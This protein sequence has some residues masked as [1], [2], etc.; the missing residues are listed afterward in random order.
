MKQLL[1]LFATLIL[2]YSCSKSKPE[3]KS[4]T[5][6]VTLQYKVNGVETLYSGD[7]GAPNNEGIIAWKHLT[8]IGSFDT[9]YFIQALKGSNNLIGIGITTDSLHAGRSYIG[10]S[11]F[12]FIVFN[13][14]KYAISDNSGLFNISITRHFSDFIDGNFSGKLYS[15]NIQTSMPDDSITITEGEFKNVRIIY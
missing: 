10:E 8:G 14:I 12:T 13:G 9:T 4:L 6:N 3:K 5:G 15:Y 2:I 7:A 1:I 11:Q